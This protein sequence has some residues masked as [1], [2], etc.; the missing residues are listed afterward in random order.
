MLQYDDNTNDDDIRLDRLIR[1]TLNRDWSVHP[2]CTWE[3]TC[4]YARRA[5]HNFDSV[6]LFQHK[7]TTCQYQIFAP[8]IDSKKITEI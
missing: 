6:D 2:S 1:A 3:D 4:I 7:D 5:V 8:S